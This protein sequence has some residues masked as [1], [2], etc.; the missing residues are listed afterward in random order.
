MIGPAGLGDLRLRRRADGADDGRAEMLAPLAEDLPDAAG[1][2]VDQDGVARLHAIGLAQQVLGSEALQHH[3]RR[4]LEADI[5]GQLDQML[6]VDIARLGVG[7]GRRRIGD[8]VADLEARDVG[9]ERGDDAGALAAGNERQ[10]CRIEPGAEI[11]V[12]VIDADGVMADARLPG[13]GRG[14]L[15]LL[16]LQDFR[17]AG[18]MDADGAHDL[19]LSPT[20]DGLIASHIGA[21]RQGEPSGTRACPFARARIGTKRRRGESARRLASA[22]IV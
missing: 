10:L 11:D 3:R 2:G 17:T 5:I 14:Q 19:S 8:A 13:A 7:A 22:P 18:L 1:R 4:L 20:R 16:Q 9:A 15:D 6:D 21:C 12:E